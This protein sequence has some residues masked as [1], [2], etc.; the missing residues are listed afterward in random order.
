MKRTSILRQTGLRMFLKLTPHCLCFFL[1]VHISSLSV[2][3]LFHPY[4]SLAV[5]ILFFFLFVCLLSLSLNLNLPL[6]LPLSLS[7]PL[8]F[9]LSLYLSLSFLFSFSQ[10]PIFLLSNISF[11]SVFPSSSFIR[12][13][14]VS[15]TG[16]SHELNDVIVRVLQ[17]RLSSLSS[18]STFERVFLHGQVFPFVLIC[19]FP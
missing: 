16:L 11:E 2:F 7:M 13:T 12:V 18:F 3:P 5:S 9:Y 15:F 19:R 6:S 14:I 1:C 17:L 8:V 4:L 10:F